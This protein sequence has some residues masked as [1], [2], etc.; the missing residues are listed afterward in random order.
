M[1]PKPKPTSRSLKD[2]RDGSG[3]PKQVMAAPHD[4]PAG[5]DAM[6][7][8]APSSSEKTRR[9][10]KRKRFSLGFKTLLLGVRDAVSARQAR[11]VHQMRLS[12]LAAQLQSAY[13]ASEVQLRKVIELRAADRKLYKEDAKSLKKAYKMAAVQGQACAF[14]LCAV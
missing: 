3:R 2:S 12:W 7:R 6:C 5:H 10:E 8:Q 13:E 11:A 14:T 4:P 1:S 9:A